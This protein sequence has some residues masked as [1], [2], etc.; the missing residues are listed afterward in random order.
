MSRRILGKQDDGWKTYLQKKYVYN[1]CL[2]GNLRVKKMEN[3]RAHNVFKKKITP[4][5]R[6]KSLM[7][8]F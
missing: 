4:F 7:E 8:S 2:A 1:E 6:L 5:R 3:F